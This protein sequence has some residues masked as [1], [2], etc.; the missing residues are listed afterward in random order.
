METWY[1]Y[2]YFCFMKEEKQITPTAT[3]EEKSIVQMIANGKTGE[4]I[5][6]EIGQNKNTFAFNLKVIRAK[7]DCANSTELVALFMRNKLIK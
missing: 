3:E 5:S 1:E 6:K 7:F 2:P 4:D